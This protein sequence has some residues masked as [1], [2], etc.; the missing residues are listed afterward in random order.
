MLDLHT[1]IL[2]GIDDGPK[3][4][5]DALSMLK[6]AAEDGITGIAATP[7]V[8]FG[9]FVSPRERVLELTAEM[10]KRAAELFPDKN[11]KVFSGSEITV[12][13]E[14]LS[15]LKE[16]RFC[17][18]NSGRYVLLELPPHFSPTDMNDFLDAVTALGQ[19]PV[20]AHPERNPRILSDMEP[21]YSFAG[22]GALMQVTAGS[23]TG[24]FGSEVKNLAMGLLERDLVH[25]VASDAHSPKHRPPALSE[26]FKVVSSSAGEE[27][28]LELFTV[29]TGKI[30][31][32]EPIAPSPPKHIQKPEI[33]I[34][35]PDSLDF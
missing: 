35:Y 2:P 14:A 25:L 23:F 12:S 6:A 21:L 34:F 5:E 26:A 13:V 20:I 22:K 10:N 8:K 30:I 31:N 17:S 27:K 28:A 33:F 24:F 7:H 11:L 16:G 1:H 32:S 3:T 9:M 4:W 29:N 19:V 18:Y 15:G